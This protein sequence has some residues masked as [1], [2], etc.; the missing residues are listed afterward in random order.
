MAYSCLTEVRA[1]EQKVKTN[2][3]IVSFIYGLEQYYF[4]S[5]E[6]EF[7]VEIINSFGD[8]IDL[9][10]RKLQKWLN[11]KERVVLHYTDQDG[12]SELSLDSLIVNCNEWVIAVTAGQPLQGTQLPVQ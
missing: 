12:F 9:M 1:F 3:F 4:Q 6:I 2:I 8:Q 10:K 11:I 7:V 5:R